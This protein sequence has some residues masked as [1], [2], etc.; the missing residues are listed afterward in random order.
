MSEFKN[1]FATGE[2]T[3]ARHSRA[4]VWSFILGC[5]TIA[6]LFGGLLWPYF[7]VLHLL[8]PLAIVL[9]H[10]GLRHTSGDTPVRRG[11]YAAVFGLYIGYFNLAIMLFLI[12]VLLTGTAGSGAP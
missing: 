5:A 9:G 10:I 11:R 12:F 4:A 6:G 7:A 3:P 8:F 2:P 1:V